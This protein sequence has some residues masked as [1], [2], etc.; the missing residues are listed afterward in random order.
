VKAV[1]KIAGLRPRCVHS[2]VVFVGDSE[3]KTPMPP[4]VV[5][6]RGLIPYVR[7]MTDVLLTENEVERAVHALESAQL[8]D[9]EAKHGRNAGGG[10]WG[11][12]GY[13]K[14]RA[15]KPA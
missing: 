9:K 11:C 15:T 3:F 10:F 6:R 4:N 12:S 2:V 13:P 1:E 14:C 5:Y 7:S 8:S